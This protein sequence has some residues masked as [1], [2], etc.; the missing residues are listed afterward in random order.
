MQWSACRWCRLYPPLVV[1]NWDT[2]R[3]QRRRQPWTPRQKTQ[4]PG[5]HPHPEV[6]PRR[7]PPRLS[8]Q[9]HRQ[10]DDHRGRIRGH[11]RIESRTLP[12]HYGRRERTPPPSHRRRCE[13]PLCSGREEPDSNIVTFSLRLRG[14]VRGNLKM[15]QSEI[16]DLGESRSR[17]N[18]TVV[19]GGFIHHHQNHQLRIFY[20]YHA[21]K[22]S[23]E[24]FV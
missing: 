19:R 13:N 16:S 11:R 4:S 18:G 20:G 23:N 5:A 24:A 15:L 10:T 14:T 2:R 21:H 8:P 6:S 3:K 9:L 22:R 12:H 1:W 7:V 17:H